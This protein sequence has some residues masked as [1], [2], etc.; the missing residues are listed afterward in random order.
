MTVARLAAARTRTSWRSRFRIGEGGG[1]HCFASQHASLAPRP[2]RAQRLSCAAKP[3][4]KAPD[5]TGGA[6]TAQHRPALPACGQPVAQVPAQPGFVKAVL[7][8]L[9]NEPN[10][11]DASA[12]DLQQKPTSCTNLV[13]LRSNCMR[14][15][16][17]GVD[18]RICPSPAKAA[19]RV[20]FKL[21]LSPDM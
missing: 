18:G 5:P 12:S 16:Q 8:N 7:K 15:S 6:G 21:I 17:R 19:Y 9:Q 20:T 4:G 13:R 14:Q 2:Q 1:G 11:H 10:A 3:F